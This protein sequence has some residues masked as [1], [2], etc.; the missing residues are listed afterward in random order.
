MA[1]LNDRDEITKAVCKR[2]LLRD[3]DKTEEYRKLQL[4]LESFEQEDCAE[5]G[6]YEARLEKCRRCDSLYQGICKKCGCFV[7]ARALRKR[8]YC[9]HENP[10][11]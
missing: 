4:Y 9:P 6:V 11:W 5:S 10:R 3:M 7:E 8:G 2:C 1:G